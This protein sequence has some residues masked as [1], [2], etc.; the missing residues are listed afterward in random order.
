MSVRVGACLVS[1]IVCEPVRPQIQDLK[2][3]LLLEPPARSL[4]E[5]SHPAPRRLQQTLDAVVA[6]ML[7]Q[8]PAL[9]IFDDN[10]GARNENQTTSDLG[11][12]CPR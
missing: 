2:A 1:R 11:R 8:D 7:K 10:A 5:G 12:S 9:R 4:D 3:R 6:S